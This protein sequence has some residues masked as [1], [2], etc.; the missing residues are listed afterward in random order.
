MLF[1]S[2]DNRR[3]RPSY[4]NYGAACRIV[5]RIRARHDFLLQILHEVLNL[6]L[7]L[8]HAFAHLQ[9]DRNPADVHTQVPRQVQNELEPLQVFIRVEPGIALG[10][11]RL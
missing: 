8:F 7:H 11:G 5:S 10:P 6:P 1:F 4:R 2:I 3:K 9:D